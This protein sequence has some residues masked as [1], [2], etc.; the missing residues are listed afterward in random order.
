MSECR[1]EATHKIAT[2]K[3]MRLARKMERPRPKQNMRRMEPAFATDALQCRA[4]EWTSEASTIAFASSKSAG[5]PEL[6]AST[7]VLA[8]VAADKFSSSGPFGA[9]KHDRPLSRETWIE[10][11]GSA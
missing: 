3:G 8:R 11:V 6:P 10:K 5:F 1:S 9:K 2:K 4:S 7:R